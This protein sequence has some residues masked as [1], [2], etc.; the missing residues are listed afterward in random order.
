MLDN[1]T[2]FAFEVLPFSPVLPRKGSDT[3]QVHETVDGE[4]KHESKHGAPLNLD[5]VL[6]DSTHLLTICMCL[7]QSTPEGNFQILSSCFGG[8][9]DPTVKSFLKLERPTR[10]KT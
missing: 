1:A 3:K 7:G 4:C 9:V 10:Q 6:V 8:I 5:F 2:G